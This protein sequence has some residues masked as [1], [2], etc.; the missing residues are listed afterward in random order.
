MK[1]VKLSLV[2]ALAAGSFSALDAKP[3]EE[4][5]RHVDLTGTLRYRYESASWGRDATR[6]NFQSL[7]QLESGM[8]NRGNK[9]IGGYIGDNN[10][11]HKFRAFITPKI[12]I[13]DGLKIVGQLMYNNDANG[14][15]G[16]TNW[17]SETQSAYDTGLA[18]TKNSVVLKQAYVQYD[19]YG[20]GT[21]ILLGRQQ[22][23]TIWTADF[24]GMA[25]KVQVKPVD[26]LTIAAFAVDSFEGTDGDGDAAKLG[27]L[28]RADGVYSGDINPYS[29]N[30]YGAAVIGDFGPAKFQ[31][32]GAYWDQMARLYA[33]D[34]RLVARFSEEG[35]DNV[36]LK[37][38]YLGN[39]LL[40][41]LE[42]VTANTYDNGNLF[43]A[44][45]FAKIAGLDFRVGGITF[46][47]K[48]KNTIN[49]LE[50][51]TG[52]DLLIGK[53]IF[54]GTGGSNNNSWIV[55]SK[56]LNVFGY[57]GIGYTLPGDVRI[58]V[59][60][61]FGQNI[62]NPEIENL[63]RHEY[64]RG[65]TEDVK[66]TKYEGVVELGW[67]ATKNLSFE[68]YYSYV[69]ATLKDNN[70]ADSY[71]QNIADNTLYEPTEHYKESKQSVRFQALYK[72]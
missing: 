11:P 52:P 26:S 34:L 44:R 23:G 61:V 39:A 62:Y 7:Q 32:W 13:G 27:H 38:T 28:T 25:A 4:A 16:R 33:A 21:S 53:E 14:G 18:A 67:K 45:F 68:A 71:G 22:L 66:T 50:D 46:G 24:T 64:N 65:L 55:Q 31:V 41:A 43:D 2:A 19:I 49:T 6:N 37:F 20:A 48:Q 42:N 60:G 3:L 72:F 57:A 63:A 47:K 69:V 58:G 54:Y 29:N 1:L 51:I 70:G 5:I 59:E 12:D 8:D 15:W 56:G 35:R 9:L 36:G 30:M 10:K 17:S 40:P